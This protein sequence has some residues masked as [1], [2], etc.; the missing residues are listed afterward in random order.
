MVASAMARVLILVRLA[1]AR[2]D[3]QPVTGQQIARRSA[4]LL[5]PPLLIIGQLGAALVVAARLILVGG[6]PRG[7]PAERARDGHVPLNRPVALRESRHRGA[8]DCTERDN[9]NRLSHG[10]LSN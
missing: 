1:S 8:S 10:T 4:G 7:A 3:V 6:L 9:P 5:A 2:D